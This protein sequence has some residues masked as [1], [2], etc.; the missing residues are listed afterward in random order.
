MSPSGSSITG[1]AA[2]ILFAFTLRL[3]IAAPATASA[4]TTNEVEYAAL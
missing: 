3:R 4:H 2:R 1:A